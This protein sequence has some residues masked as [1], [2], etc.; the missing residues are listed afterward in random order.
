[1]GDGLSWKRRSTSTS[2]SS[3]RLAPH[4]QTAQ[5]I[6]PVPDPPLPCPPQ[7][8]AEYRSQVEHLQQL[9]VDATHC[10]AFVDQSRQRLVSE[11]EAWYT[12]AFL[13]EASPNA[14]P[15]PSTF[16]C[17]SKSEE[18]DKL[19]QKLLPNDTLGFYRART[20]TDMRV[21]VLTKQWVSCGQALG[22]PACLPISS[23]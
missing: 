20:R 9:R 12:M 10:Q 11:F 3:R 2:W 13:G 21:S 23:Y 6:A 22:L 4:G 17:I 1:M 18:F 14:N 5:S 8:K 16:E 15:S 7:L 19:Q